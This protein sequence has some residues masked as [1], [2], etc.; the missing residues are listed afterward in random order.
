[1]GAR[2]PPHCCPYQRLGDGV[3]TLV[4][5]HILQSLHTDLSCRHEMGF[6]RV[7]TIHVWQNSGSIQSRTYR[8]GSLALR[9]ARLLGDA[10][11]S[12]YVVKNANC[13][14][15]Q[16]I[17]LAWTHYPPHTGRGAGLS[18]QPAGRIVLTLTQPS[19]SDYTG[20]VW[21]GVEIYSYM[22]PMHTC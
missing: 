3:S 21:Y 18:E 4:S 1:M 20:P 2:P 15:S 14:D 13:K 9:K 19:P 10:Y 8:L 17:R 12:C 6:H 7:Q 11:L 16:G 22:P 5:H